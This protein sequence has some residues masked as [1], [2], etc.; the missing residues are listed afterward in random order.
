MFVITFSLLISLSHFFKHLL[1]NF[2]YGMCMVYKI[3]GSGDRT[4]VL[5]NRL[6]SW[7]IQGLFLA[8][9]RYFLFFKTSR[10]V[11]GPTQL[12]FQGYGGFYPWEWSNRGV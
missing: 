8:G 1:W 3:Y 12:L 10:P 2:I 9:T 6:H 5:V 4:D 7:T 11:L